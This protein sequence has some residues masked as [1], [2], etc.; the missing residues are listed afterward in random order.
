MSKTN[1][2][3]SGRVRILNPNFRPGT[4]TE[5]KE[6]I[7]KFMLPGKT[8]AALG[9]M[10]CWLPAI[11]YVAENYN[12][13]M[14]H[15]VIPSFFTPIASSVLRQYPH[16]RIHENRI[17]DRLLDGVALKEQMLLPI[18]ATGAHLVDLGFI[19]FCHLSPPPE[20]EDFYPELDLSD[21]EI[22][23]L[24]DRYVVMT[25]IMEA[26]T[27]TMPAATYN[28]ICDYLIS[29]GITPIHLGKTDMAQ[30]DLK[31]NPEYD[32]SKGINL[33]DSTSL[34]EAARIMKESLMVIG[35]DNGLLHLAGMTDATILYGYTIA[36]PRQRQ[37]RRRSGHLVE[38]YADKEKLPCLFCQEHTRFF[39]N[40][41]FRN[42]IY[43]E[44]TPQCVRDLNIESY[45]ATIDQVLG[46]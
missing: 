32:L 15:L 43:K 44:N 45:R 6:V 40:H 35:I 10:I 17:P 37:I 12:F 4:E 24:P 27:R 39:L 22:A 20:G 36:G 16:W 34:L 33:L 41:D 30:R 5:P 2:L 11:R 38:M 18:N 1:S 31:L 8:T 21:V 9:D 14:G 25:P 23:P 46:G 28:G 26:A 3:T 19:Y 7:F 42:C 29:K 13:V